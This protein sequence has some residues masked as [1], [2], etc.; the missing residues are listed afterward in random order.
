MERQL[1]D[2][3]ARNRVAEVREFYSDFA[4]FGLAAGVAGVLD[5][6]GWGGQWL[7]W[8]LGIWA[9]V[10]ASHALNVFVLS[11]RF[12]ADWEERRAHELA[13]RR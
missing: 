8:V 9:F 5:V 11:G 13:A 2:D 6:A 1:S 12:D 7:L 10:L 3:R 4:A